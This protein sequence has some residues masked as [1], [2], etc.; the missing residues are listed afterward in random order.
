MLVTV[1]AFAYIWLSDFK[2]TKGKKN[3]R[4]VFLLVFSLSLVLAVLISS[5][6]DVVSPVKAIQ[7]AMEF[8]H[9]NY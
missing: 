9:I 7:S 3:E 2:H 8:M 1:I 6:T 5:D 4:A